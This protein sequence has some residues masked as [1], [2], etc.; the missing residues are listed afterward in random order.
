MQFFNHRW[1]WKP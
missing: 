1:R